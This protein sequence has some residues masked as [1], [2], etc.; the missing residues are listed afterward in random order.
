[1]SKAIRWQVPFASISG[2][3]YRVDIYDE[4]DGTW[5]GITQLLAGGTPFVTN[6]DS[7]K[8]F[9]APLR[10]Q[11]GTLQVCT[12]MTDGG[13]L[14]IEDI[15]PETNIAR[16]LILVSI[17]SSEH[18]RVE[19]HGFLSCEAYSQN[20]TEI[21]EVLSLPIISVL[22]A[23]RCVEFSS[24]YYPQA[25]SE[26]IG[27]FIDD[28]LTQME[29]DTTLQISTHYSASSSDILSKY[30]F[31]SQY[32]TY[33]KDEA[34]GNI[35]Y[36]YSSASLYTILED[37]CK[38][39]GWVLREDGDTFYFV[40]IGSDELG[41]TT[42]NMTDLEWMGTNHTLT[43]M[44]GAKKVSV[45]ANLKDFE[46]SFE[47]PICPTLGLSPKNYYPGYVAIPEWYYDKCTQANVGMFTSADITKCFL[48]RFYG[49]RNDSTIPWDVVYED[50]GFTNTLYLTGHKYT[51]TSYVKLCTIKSALE[52]SVIC[53]A[54]NTLEDVGHLILTI[55]EETASKLQIQNGYIRCGLKYLGKYYAFTSVWTWVDNPNATFTVQLNNGNGE[56]R[57]ELPK[58]RDVY[59]FASSELELYIYDD[60]D[61]NSRTSALITDLNITF[62]PPFKKN[63]TDSKSNLYIQNVGTSRD[64]IKVDLNLASSLGNRN[65]PSLLYQVET[66][67]YGQESL[68]HYEPIKSLLYVLPGG[69]T[70]ARRPEVD[71]INRLASYYAAARTWLELIVKHPTAVA[72]PM[73]KLNGINDGKKYLPLSESRD[74]RS[75]ECT[76][77]CFETPE[78]PSES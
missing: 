42:L 48:C 8:D 1:M 4:Q 36:V 21:P 43:I 71:L 58:L 63:L 56:L 17:D 13:I 11:T 54:Y 35:T 46:T 52:L 5:S 59:T 22:E 29:Y 33:D 10:P 6:E 23:M 61:I 75:E 69:T 57:I 77:T 62:E 3:K 41:M 70:E 14:R 50:I 60:F 18:E 32:F 65:S 39:M 53:A 9:F 44:Q 68:D 31:V 24:Y 55:K 16:P 47:M 78:E 7:S 67:Y 25:G 51:D 74:W 38:F 12:R 15:I 64:E 73:L 66:Y 27:N 19:W 26:T 72:L 20:Y 28:I 76:L 34:T 2:T 37:I 49:L 45:E 30:I 40:R